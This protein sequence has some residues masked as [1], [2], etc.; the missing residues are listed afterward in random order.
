MTTS[1][2]KVMI[3]CENC[4]EKIDVREELLKLPEVQRMHVVGSVLGSKRTEK[5]R[6][7]SIRN[8]EKANAAKQ[9]HSDELAK[10]GSV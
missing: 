2:T 7:A 8:L 1:K 5:R 6:L 9:R 10:S 4:L 3:E